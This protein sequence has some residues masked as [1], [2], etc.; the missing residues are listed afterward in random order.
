LIDEDFCCRE[1]REKYFASFRKSLTQLPDLETPVVAAGDA[2]TTAPAAS[3]SEEPASH[4]S[5][6]SEPADPR[7]ADFLPASVAPCGGP[8]SSRSAGPDALAACRAIEMPQAAASWFA[9]LEHEHR[10][11]ELVEPI[12]ISAAAIAPEVR[13]LAPT[14]VTAVAIVPSAP[15]L[16]G[17]GLAAGGE[18][19][20]PGEA[21]PC[22][23]AE[24]SGAAVR[25]VMPSYSGSLT[26]VPSLM[27]ADAAELALLC[28]Q[29][30]CAAV[31]AT[32]IAL[33]H[34]YHVPVFAASSKSMQLDE[35]D[36]EAMAVPE[37]APALAMSSS[38][39]G[40]PS[41][42]TANS[43]VMIRPALGL[44]SPGSPAQLTVPA[45]SAQPSLA[46]EAGI[47]GGQAA[48]PAAGPRSHEAVRPSFWSSVRI[49]NWR[50]RITFA[51]PA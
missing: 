23:R 35:A 49:K 33:A 15:S 22:A 4:T 32:E 51:K 13:L 34:E 7:M 12:A 5:L 50:L 3:I 43:P 44:A 8:G 41:S 36:A 30:E 31:A 47:P 48:N 19:G 40:Y 45:L 11:A 37:L 9:T 16:Q 39:V 18:N 21:A 28:Q 24:I 29:P 1:H 14:L 20:V 2:I 25:L 26:G 10:P 27:L 6:V 17:A 38:P 46:P 42:H